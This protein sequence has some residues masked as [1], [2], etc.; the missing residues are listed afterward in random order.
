VHVR[1]VAAAGLAAVDALASGRIDGVHACNVASGTPHTIGEF[2]AS[3]AAATAG[4]D[5][6]VT[7]QYRLGDVRHVVADP[8]AAVQLLGFRARTD[9]AEGVREFATA[10]LRSTGTAIGANFPGAVSRPRAPVG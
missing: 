8:T 9:F 4:P 1:D 5:P 2:A 3:L 10:P 7:G 6:V